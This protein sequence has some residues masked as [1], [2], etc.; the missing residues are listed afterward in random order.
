MIGFGKL[1]HHIVGRRVTYEQL[2]GK[3][4]DSIHQ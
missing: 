4:V 1:M 2:T 3:G